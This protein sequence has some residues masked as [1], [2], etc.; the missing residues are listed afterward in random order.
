MIIDRSVHGV[1][2]G[3]FTTTV[4]QK[5]ANFTSTLPQPITGSGGPHLRPQLHKRDPSVPR[6]AC[7]PRAEAA[8]HEAAAVGAV[9][10]GYVLQPAHVR[11]EGV[12]AGVSVGETAR[13]G[14]QCAR[15]LLGID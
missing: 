2:P 15:L 10:H 14:Q 7:Q 1:A 4:T 9:R 13:R 8:E 12:S 5:M 6:A 11:A 3:W